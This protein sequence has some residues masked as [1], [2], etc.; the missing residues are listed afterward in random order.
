MDDSKQKNN[1]NSSSKKLKYVQPKLNF[2]GKLSK[3]TLAGA[4]GTGESGN[5]GSKKTT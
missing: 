2:F 5:Q 1:T 3:L 4:T